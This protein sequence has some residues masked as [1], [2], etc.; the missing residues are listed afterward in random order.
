[1]RKLRFALAA[2]VLATALPRSAPA[3]F[4][5]EGKFFRL[6]GTFYSQSRFRLQDSS[7]P[8][9]PQTQ[10]TFFSGG[11]PLN[12]QMGNLVQWRNY[13]APVFEGNLTKPLG[14][15]N[16]FDELSFRFAG[17]FVYDGIYDF[18]PD[19]FRQH[20][21]LYHVS[22]S[23]P[24]KDGTVGLGGNQ[25]VPIYRGT[26]KVE[27]D[28]T[29]IGVPGPL[30]LQLGQAQP[31]VRAARLRDQELFDPREE[32]AQQMEP[33]EIYVN[34]QKGP[35]FL[36]LGRQNLSWGETDGIRLLDVINPID[37]FFG[38]TF[39]EDLDEKRIPLWMARTNVQLIDN[40]GP[41]S[42][43]GVESFLV[44]G[45]ID[46]TQSPVLFQ[47]FLHP[48]APP[49]GCDAQLIADNNV[50]APIV[51]DSNIPPG[52]RNAV[53]PGNVHR[54]LVKVSLYE[55]LPNKIMKH[56]R[57]G[58]R[59]VGVLFGDYT[60]SLA[61]YRT[62]ADNP[63]PRVHYND[64]IITPVKLTVPQSALIELT[65][66]R[67]TIVGGTLSFY[68]RR[69][70]PGVV[71]TEFGYFFGEP[72]QVQLAN[73][74]DGPSGITNTFVP[75]ADFIRW[76]I[77]YDVFELNV[78][79]ISRSNNIILI[80]QWFNSVRLTSN[81]P[82][83]KLVKEA[84]AAVARNLPATPDRAPPPYV[85]DD[86]GKFQLVANPGRVGSKPI[87]PGVFDRYNATWSVAL[88][89]FMM[90]GNLIPQIV[91]VA[92]TEGDFGFLPSF[93]YRINDSLQVKVGYAGIYGKFSQLGLFRDRDQV[94]IRVSY[95]IN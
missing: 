28:A 52:C 56:S 82:Y 11:T 23:T 38:L 57:F 92:F 51:G 86:F 79:W 3:L 29:F 95:L 9:G 73:Q 8:K 89:A 74:G 53:T 80:T 62:W 40:W 76:M 67:E 12:T 55:R 35:A 68:Q 47:G 46:A 65:H 88:Q 41:L 4:L 85:P 61:A 14:V 42:S 26:K 6:S 31:D 58:A 33:W 5:D 13:A 87:L 71:R 17:R 15:Q 18:G 64:E 43:V 48:Y 70:L 27:R 32:F 90:H 30:P 44:P 83:D 59:F 2:M 1:M 77:G 69:L 50:A 16:W 22:A 75:Q 39:D 66:G 81:A 20:L 24:A 10:T 84:N 37:N 72:G 45:A 91:G 60:V 34:L 78:P 93:V 19:E 94:G 54:G 7:G 36:R 21:R 25:P 49:T 63:A